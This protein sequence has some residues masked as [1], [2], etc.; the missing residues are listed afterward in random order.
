MKKQRN[1][2]FTFCLA[3]M[4]GAAQMFLGFIKYGLS[5]MILFFAI[6]A[7]SDFTRIYQFNYILPIIWFFS[8]FDA[9][10]RRWCSPETF[11]SLEDDYLFKSSNLSSVN[12][13][14]HN[15]GKL[16][17]GIAVIVVGLS[18]F[19]RTFVDNI[20]YRFN[21]HFAGILYN[22]LNALIPIIIAVLII[23]FG[24]YLIIGKKKG[25]DDNV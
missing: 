17:L 2:F 24:V 15:K 16:I 3:F 19:Y 25:N 7:F 14:F 12:K 4:P 20:L 1:K 8:F 11:N 6:I 5:I 9:I 21:S 22:T 23:L 10:N 18:I 13:L